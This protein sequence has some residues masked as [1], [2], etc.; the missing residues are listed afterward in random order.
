MLLYMHAHVHN[1]STCVFPCAAQCYLYNHMDIAK[2]L[3]SK[4]RSLGLM[5]Y[6]KETYKGESILHIA[7]IHKDTPAVADVVRQFP[8]LLAERAVGDFFAPGGTCYYGTQP[9]T[10]HAREGLA[11]RKRVAPASSPAAHASRVRRSRLRLRLAFSRMLWSQ[12]SKA[13]HK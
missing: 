1:I 5:L 7:I 6:Q 8:E 3:L 4:R 9:E 13:Y 12:N 11:C 2:Y 10:V